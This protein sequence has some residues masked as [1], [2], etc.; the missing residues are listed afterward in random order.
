MMKCDLYL[1]VRL[2]NIWHS[3]PEQFTQSWPLLNTLRLNDHWKW[4]ELSYPQ[5]LGL[6]GE[7]NPQDYQENRCPMF[8]PLRGLF[9]IKS[10]HRLQL[11]GSWVR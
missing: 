2:N 8:N 7:V 11:F 9:S 6:Q 10:R 4:P 3:K 1:Y 5:L